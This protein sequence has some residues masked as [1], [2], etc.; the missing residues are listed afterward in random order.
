[1]QEAIQQIRNGT[2]NMVELSPQAAAVRRWQHDMA[3]EANLLSLS[4]GKE[5]HRRV[6]IFRNDR[7]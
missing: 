5:P 6:R 7:G 4:R 1:M 3:R 2:R